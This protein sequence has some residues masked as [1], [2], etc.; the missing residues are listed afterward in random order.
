MRYLI[1]LVCAGMILGGCGKRPERKVSL[2][3]SP[4]L[5]YFQDQRTGLCF[6]VAKARWYQGNVKAGLAGFLAHV[7][8]ATVMKAGLLT[9]KA[10]QLVPKHKHEC[11]IRG[12]ELQG[13]DGRRIVGCVK[14]TLQALDVMPADQE[15]ILAAISKLIRPAP[16]GGK[17]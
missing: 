5:Q 1:L 13:K 6:A 4:H 10:R 17:R 2:P 14:K 12:G 11:G 16:K 8:C 9:G 15:A 3:P 7:P